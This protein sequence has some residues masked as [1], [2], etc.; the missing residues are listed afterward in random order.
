[1]HPDNKYIQALLDNSHALLKELYDK[2]F[3]KIRNMIIRNGGS[4]DDAADIMQEALLAIYNRAKSHG[5][6]LTC[7][8]EAFL[9]HACRNKWINEVQKRKKLQQVTFTDTDGYDKIG[10]DSFAL[11]EDC[12]RRQEQKELF[13]R[14]F[15][16]LGDACKKL[17]RLNWSGKALDDVAQLLNMTYGY[18]RKK[19]SECMA[20]LA[21]LVQQSPDYE[22]LKR[23]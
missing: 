18:V 17:L 12:I 5:F 20:K 4:A 9:Y 13:E 1:M 19:K 15:E 6:E 10:E 14:H 3:D 2:Y 11:A 22:N 16:T 8:M 21:L 23:K 7:P